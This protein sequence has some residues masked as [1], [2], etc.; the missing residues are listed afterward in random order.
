MSF[1]DIDDVIFST[2]ANNSS[3]KSNGLLVTI[4]FFINPVRIG[5]SLD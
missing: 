4:R 2:E 1:I 5:G 3:I